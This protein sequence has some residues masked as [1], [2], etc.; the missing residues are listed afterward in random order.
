M[1]GTLGPCCTNCRCEK[2]E[3]TRARKG[4]RQ[5]T[6]YELGFANDSMLS[7]LSAA[8]Q[9][10][11]LLLKQSKH[12]TQKDQLI[13]QIMKSCRYAPSCLSSPSSSPSSPCLC[14]DFF[15][16]A[17]LS[18]SYASFCPLLTNLRTSSLTSTSSV[19]PYF[20]PSVS[21]PSLA[22]LTATVTSLCPDDAYAF[23]D[24]PRLK[25][26]SSAL[27]ASHYPFLSSETVICDY[28]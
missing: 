26:T 13:L 5:E 21:Y 4:A 23:Y 24:F 15:S 16:D 17:Y 2:H 3:Q 6:V 1:I 8:R 28:S 14:S 7:P 27:G 25:P 22:K 11:L 19:S 10:V 12:S 20:C 18:S 9:T